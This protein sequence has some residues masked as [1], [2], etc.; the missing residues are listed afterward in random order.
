MRVGVAI[1]VLVF[2]SS[3]WGL[4]GKQCAFSGR[5]SLGA[6]EKYLATASRFHASLRLCLGLVDAFREGKPTSA[7][8]GGREG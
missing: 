4:V 3:Y 5:L 2:A 8:W 1:V 6:L 7:L